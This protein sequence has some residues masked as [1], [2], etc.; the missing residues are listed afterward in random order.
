MSRSVK[1]LLLHSQAQH[2][3]CD[4]QGC[5]DGQH[6]GE[7]WVARLGLVGHGHSEGLACF[8]HVLHVLYIASYPLG[9]T[10]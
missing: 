8:V 1:G 6:D 10:G 5:Q 2:E 3:G 7:D 4:C 9:V